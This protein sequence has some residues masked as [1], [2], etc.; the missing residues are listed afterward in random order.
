MWS[1]KEREREEMAWREERDVTGNVVGLGR[2]EAGR[3]RSGEEHN[4]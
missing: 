4:T 1:V 2:R 3:G